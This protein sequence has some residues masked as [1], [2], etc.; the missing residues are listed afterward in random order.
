MHSIRIFNVIIV[1]ELS[2]DS[3]RRH[4]LVFAVAVFF[5]VNFVVGVESRVTGGGGFDSRR[6][7]DASTL[8]PDAADDAAA[9]EIA[10]EYAVAFADDAAAA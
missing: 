4:Q 3:F 1:V 5:V 2:V 8:R 9:A 6:R 7:H 10:A